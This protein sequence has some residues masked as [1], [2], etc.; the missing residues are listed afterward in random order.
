MRGSNDDARKPALWF[1]ALFLWLPSLGIAAYLLWQCRRLT[2]LLPHR[3]YTILERLMTEAR[4]LVDYLYLLVIPHGGT[5]GLYTKVTVS[6]GL[7]DPWTTLPSILIVVALLAFAFAVRRRLPVL[8]A[9]ILFYFAGQLI[10][11]TT[12]PLELYYEHR[13]YLPAALLL[14]PLAWWILRGPGA[15]VLR[16]A[17]AGGAL[18]LLLALT[19][20]RAEL[21]GNGQ[22]LAMAW[23]RM[24]PNSARAV[25]WGSRQLADA[26]HPKLALKR[27]REATGRQ[28]GDISISLTAL[29]MA[30][31]MHAA[32][33]S[34][35]AAVVYAAGHSH[36]GSTLLYRNITRLARRID[37][38]PC[39][40]L[41]TAALLRIPEAALHNPYF[42]R[43]PPLQQE[44]LILRGRLLLRMGR[45]QAAYEAFSRA[46]PLVVKPDAALYVAAYM[47]AADAPR[48]GL[49]LLDEYRALP[50]PER[51]G[52]SMKR[53]H[54]WWLERTG[55]YSESFRRVREALQ[56]KPHSGG[57]KNP[58]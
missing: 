43:Y 24:N 19:A 34:D 15:R 1:R 30:C 40:P 55:W 26:G 46:L 47:Y 25:V 57:R 54:R 23:L 10:E 41:S 39:P 52:W 21:W 36:A 7:L 31:R 12:I 9:A 58:T 17:I 45:E 51:D 3:G 8:A 22:A 16:A 49:E 6:H 11:S 29:I 13:N 20:Y 32:R 50:Q 5:D 2:E 18:A 35:L 56:K 48:L 38:A 27:L 37:R 14:W 4:V 44:F 33:P 28:R 42:A 53:L